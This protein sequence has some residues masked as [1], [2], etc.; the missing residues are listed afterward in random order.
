[1]LARVVSKWVLLGTTWPGAHI[2]V[3]G[4]VRPPPLVGRDDVAEAGQVLDRPLS[5]PKLSLPA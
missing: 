3:K 2:T 4:C 5:R 1:M